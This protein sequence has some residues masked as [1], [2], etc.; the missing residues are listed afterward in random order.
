MFWSDMVLPR[1]RSI[2]RTWLSRVQVR[3]PSTAG[4]GPAKT[5]A[6][7]TACSLSVRRSGGRYECS[8]AVKGFTLDGKRRCTTYT[9]RR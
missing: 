2:Q 7:R 8:D 5:A 3:T 4:S 9:G 6:F 1:R